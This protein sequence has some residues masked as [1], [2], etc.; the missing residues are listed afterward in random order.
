[1]QSFTTARTAFQDISQG[2]HDISVKVSAANVP[3]GVAT[4]HLPTAL[5]AAQ[6][7]Q[8]AVGTAQ[9]GVMVTRLGV[10]GSDAELIMEKAQDAASTASRCKETAM[11]ALEQLDS[12]ITGCR[13]ARATQLRPQQL[14]QHTRAEQSGLR[15]R[16][17]CVTTDLVPVCCNSISAVL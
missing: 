12:A 9:L 13:R 2:L 16:D 14:Q 5:V 7:A 1:M 11:D 3:L 15:L 6:Q 10:T 4:E 17:T 8:A